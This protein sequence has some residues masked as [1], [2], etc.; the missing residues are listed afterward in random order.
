MRGSTTRNVAGPGDIRHDEGRA[1]L[2]GRLPERFD[3]RIPDDTSWDI[4]GMTSVYHRNG[5]LVVMPFEKVAVRYAITVLRVET[6]A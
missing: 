1:Y 3:G 4:P 6:G 5:T 2:A